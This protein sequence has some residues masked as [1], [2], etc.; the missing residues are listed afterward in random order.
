MLVWTAKTELFKNPGP[1]AVPFQP[2]IQN[3]GRI[4]DCV[5]V[6]VV[7][8]DCLFGDKHCA[9]QSLCN[10]SSK[11]SKHCVFGALIKRALANSATVLPS[12][13][14]LRTTILDSVVLFEC[15]QRNSL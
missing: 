13:T 5:I 8:L 12:K 15:G 10:S 2:L 1:V 9:I 11:T 4:V 6:P 3:G 14:V 7:T